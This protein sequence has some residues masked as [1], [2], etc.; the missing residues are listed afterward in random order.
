M[1]LNYVLL[2]SIILYEIEENKR[3]WNLSAHVMPAGDQWLTDLYILLDLLHMATVLGREFFVVITRV[4]RQIT[5]GEK[6]YLCFS[7]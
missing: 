4:E 6:Y 3:H 7:L 5:I 2:H 1:M